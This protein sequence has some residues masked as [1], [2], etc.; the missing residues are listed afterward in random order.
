MSDFRLEVFYKVATLGSFTK[1]AEALYITQPAVT[2]HIRELESQW[3]LPLFER[4][5]NTIH[6]TDAGQIV[7]QHAERI[8]DAYRGLEFDLSTLKQQLSGRLRLGASTTIAQYILPPALALFNQRFPHIRV[9]LI[10]E[11]SHIVEKALLEREIDLGL[12]EN[13]S[14]NKTLKYVPFMEDELVLVT[15]THHGLY[16]KTP[17]SLKTLMGIPLVLREKG[18]GTLEV[19]EKYLRAQDLSPRDLNVRM[20][21]GSSEGIKAY[22]Q[23]SDCCSIVS[24]KTI[25]PEVASGRLRV[26]EIDNCRLLRQLSF[27]H[28]QGQAEPLPAFF[29]QYIGRS[30]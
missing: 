13:A 18:S 16:R 5:G 19:L 22:L 26:L 29:M 12:V 30:L 27:V 7:R 14:R 24:I 17:L 1:A 25:A 3:G 21:L 28:L 10:N 23:A 2:K 6:L 4:K 8:F 9:S 11:N 15:A 20:Y